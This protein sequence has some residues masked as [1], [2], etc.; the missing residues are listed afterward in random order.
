VVA[1]LARS[2]AGT[3]PNP[4]VR[5]LA[6]RFLFLFI[7]PLTIVGQIAV[8]LLHWYWIRALTPTLIN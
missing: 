1:G 5:V 8:S 3:D 7:S 6:H 4:R 2:A